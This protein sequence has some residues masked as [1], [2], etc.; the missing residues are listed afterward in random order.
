MTEMKYR[1]TIILL[2]VV[3]IGFMLSAFMPQQP[4]P[5]QAQPAFKAKNLKVLPKNITKDE[6]DDV[7]D[8]FKVAL[9]VKCGFCHAPQAADPSKLDFASDAKPEKLMARKMMKMTAQINKKYF[10]EPGM[11]GAML[12]ISC[13]TC[14]NGQE[15]PQ[16][17]SL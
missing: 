2:C 16:T 10:H 5:R 15:K 8:G 13:N 14:H 7:M 12:A 1:T 4:E 17:L 9:G 11:D 6:L 3:A